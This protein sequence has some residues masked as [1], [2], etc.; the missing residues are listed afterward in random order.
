MLA[1]GAG[2]GDPCDWSKGRANSQVEVTEWA[3]E[4]FTGMVGA[5][6]VCA[7]TGEGKKVPGGGQVGFLVTLFQT[8][9]AWEWR[10]RSIKDLV[11]N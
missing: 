5:G 8:E 6:P 2:L 3:A 1:L 11:M 7:W 9:C 10:G 4:D